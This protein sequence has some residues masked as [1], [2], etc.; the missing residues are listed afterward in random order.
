[1]NQN[2]NRI[3]YLDYTKGF[4]I[5]LMV[6]NHTKVPEILSDW[7]F[8]WHMPIFFIIG[9]VIFQYY[10]N[11]NPLHITTTTFIKKRIIQLG[12]PYFIFSILYAL[13]IW[14]LGI[15]GGSSEKLLALLF[16]IFTLQ[17]I[18]SLWFLPCYFIGE[19]LL[20]LVNQR[21]KG[22]IFLNF[23]AIFLLFIYISHLS[24][25][26]H[27]I[28]WRKNLIRFVVSY[29][30]FI[31]GYYVSKHNIID[32]M[33]FYITI[34]F[35]ATCS[36]S[37]IQN[38]HVGLGGLIFNNIWLFY[39]NAIFMSI[40]ILSLFKHLE[41]HFLFKG[42]TYFGKNTIVILCT[43]NILIEIIRLIDYKFFNNIL[44]TTGIV[45]NIILTIIILLIELPIIKITETKYS[46][47]FG[48]KRPKNELFN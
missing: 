32:R 38:G 19:I 7:T 2:I 45:G 30:F 4:T 22:S 47:I 28:W 29:S 8:A 31:I 12:I 17:G 21:N 1:M 11:N 48:K 36:Y 18:E 16:P 44:L 34:I 5:I 40:S 27:T 35:I 37:S 10:S 26:D 46:F 41:K 15:I 3:K 43:N 25:S 20:R 14:G 24:S 39:F 33:P 6:L 9:G 13:F 23:I 42:L